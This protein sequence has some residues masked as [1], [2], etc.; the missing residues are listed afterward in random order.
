MT[1]YP[2]RKKFI[3]ILV[4]F[5][6]ISCIIFLPVIYSLS[7]RLSKTSRV[8]AN[9]LLV[10]GWL[11][12]YAIEMAYNEFQNK[13][14]TYIVTTGLK[15]PDYYFVGM[16]GYLIFYPKKLISADNELPVH[17]I[18]IDAYSELGGENSSRFNVYV[19]NTLITEFSAEKRKKKY[20]ITWAGKL[21]NIDSVMVQFIND[22][23]GNSGSR[24]L[25][26]K[27][28]IIDKKI[29]IPYQNYSEYDILKPYG[30]RRIINN[31][32]SYAQLARRRLLSIGIDSSLVIAISGKR[33]KINRTLTSALAFRDW[34]KT[35]DIEIKGIN[36]VTMGT[37]ARRTWMT[38][39]KILK[40][41]YGI[42]IIS[43]PDSKDTQSKRHKILKTLRETFGLIYYWLI[44]LPY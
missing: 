16:N 11:P 33:T 40:E 9:I 41:N 34:L 42:G 13:E 12:T 18:E 25:Y 35:A 26:V 6:I 17:L 15:L 39:N 4:S 21:T 24:N 43:I 5:F 44:L 29:K 10:E 14:Y 37:H 2:V 38:Y 32:D 1:K 28:I 22:G 20:S 23:S 8:D 31:F 19:N 3:I 36:I 27:E 7:D 30:R